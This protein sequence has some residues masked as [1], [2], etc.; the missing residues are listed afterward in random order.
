M[1]EL[2]GDHAACVP[3]VGGFRHPLA[4][5]YRLEVAAV[6][7]ELLAADRLR[8]GF[9]FER[10]DTRVVRAEDFA[11]IDP[12]GESLRNLNTPQEYEAAMAVLGATDAHRQRHTSSAATSNRSSTGPS[13][14][15]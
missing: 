14:A 7:A 2:L 6:A 11:D 13:A 12:A 15:K 8:P 10:V 3:E 9:L 5:V 1:V 4:A